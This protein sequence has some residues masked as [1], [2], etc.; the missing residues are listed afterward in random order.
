MLLPFIIFVAVSVTIIGGYF[1]AAQLPGI[2]AERRLDRRLRD[3]STDS[4]VA[5]P[6]APPDETGMRHK[7]EGPLPGMDRLVSGTGAGKRMTRLIEQSGVRT[8][9]SA[10]ALISLLSA[11]SVGFLTFL[12][13]PQRF[14]PL[15]AAVVGGLI[16]IVWV[17]HRRSARLKKFEEQFP[18]ALDL[19]SRAI[20]AG[21]ALQTALGMVAEELPDPVGPE[22]KKTFEQQN[23][24]LPLRDALNEMAARVAVLDVRFFVTAVLIQRDTGGNLA[25]ILDN[26]AHVVR[27]RFKIRR[28]VRVHT[29]HGR[30][31]GYVLLA[32]PAALAIALTFINPEHMQTLFRERMGQMMLI[33]AM[34]LQ[35][36]GFFWIRQVIKIEV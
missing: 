28:Q 7:L 14:A 10:L 17:M 18:E 6:N 9:P 19:L 33:G 25:E 36:V 22:F 1:A 34:V 21:H 30:F 29:A 24:G 32:L 13:V 23:F 12:F 27:E 3:V 15:V 16:P 26:L 2:L 11:A 20:R 5:D 31:T 8:T 35:T 4:A